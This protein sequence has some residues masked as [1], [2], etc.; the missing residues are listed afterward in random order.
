LKTLIQISLYNFVL[1]LYAS[2]IRWAQPFSLKARLWYQ[3]RQHV[4]EGLEKTL[5]DFENTQVGFQKK[6]IWFHVASLGEFEQ[7]R[8]LI[9]KIKQTFPHHFILLTFF[10]PSGLEVRKNYNFANYICYL[11][12][13]TARNAERFLKIVKPDVA[14]FIK[15]EFWYHFLSA[16][17]KRHVPT[18][19]VSGLFRT[20]Q[21][22]GLYA[23]FFLKTLSS[24]THFFVQDNASVERLKNQGFLNATQMGDT[25]TDRVLSIAAEKRSF[26]ILDV[27]LQNKRALICGSTWLEDEKKILTLL[28]QPIFED[29]KCVIAPHEISE[30]RIAELENQMQRLNPSCQIIKYTQANAQDSENLRQAQ[31]LIID[32]IGLLS[33]L[34]KYA[35]IAYIGGG[36]GKGIHNILEPMAFSIPVIFGP[37]FSKFQE[38]HILVQNQGGFSVGSA[39]EFMSVFEKLSVVKSKN[40]HYPKAVQATKAY[41]S[42]NKGATDKIF[43]FLEK[44]L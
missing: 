16:L 11:P 8:P 22:K 24:F 15:Y 40:E 36:F 18:F 5:G 20:Q 44:Y 37:Q 23:H 43:S 7:G 39:Q 38:A 13:D 1:W 19:L 29:W 32:N 9:E 33:A 35:D 30:K 6:I 42:E 28:N 34:Y 4:F 3:G 10:S 27:F 2:A 17:K 21:F 41:M 14:I 25:R 31:V 12:L 26:P